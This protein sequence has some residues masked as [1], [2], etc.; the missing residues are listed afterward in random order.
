MVLAPVFGGEAFPAYREMSPTTYGPDQFVDDLVDEVATD[1]IPSFDG[2]F[3]LHGHSAGAQFAARF[4]VAHP[5]RL[6]QVV[7]SAPST[8]PFPNSAVPWPHGAGH[9]VAGRSVSLS[10]HRGEKEAGSPSIESAAPRPQDWLCAASEIPTTVLVGSL[11]LEPRLDA[12]GQRGSTRIERATAWVE[13]MR[14]YA[15]DHN[16]PQSI[17]LLI[18][19]GLDHDEEA[20][21]APAQAILSNP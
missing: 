18:I 21:T 8:Y 20:M 5:H 16:R 9:R 4:L 13:A 12:P 7:L 3:S 19:D 15:E 1:Q 2:R 14:Q 17:R 6:K 10:R 11:D